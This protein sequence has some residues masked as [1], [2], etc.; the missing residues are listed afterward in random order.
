MTASVDPRVFYRVRKTTL[1]MLRDRGYDQ[2]DATI[3]ETFDQFQ[4]MFNRA[5]PKFNMLVSRP[6]KG[7]TDAMMENVDMDDGVS[8][9]E[10]VFVV[11]HMDGTQLQCDALAKIVQK[12]EDWNTG[13]RKPNQKE[14]H[15]AILV[16]NATQT[17]AFKKVS[18]NLFCDSLSC[19]VLSR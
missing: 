8:I 7:N 15:E 2:A 19:F 6:A 17:A 14:L 11:F 10:S 9:E 13:Q 1:E 3:E 12:M 5:D 16:T 18:N 4:E